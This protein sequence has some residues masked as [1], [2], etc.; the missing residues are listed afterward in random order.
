MFTNM[1]DLLDSILVASHEQP[2]NA[3]TLPCDGKIVAH[4]VVCLHVV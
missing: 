1:K 2:D 3:A 4:H